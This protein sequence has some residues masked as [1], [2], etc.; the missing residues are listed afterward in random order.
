VAYSTNEPYI[1][2]KLSTPYVIFSPR[3]FGYDFYG[4]NLCTS[5]RQVAEHPEQVSAF[6]AAS[7]KGWQYALEHKEEI[8]DLILRRYPT[9]KTRDALLFEAR[10]TELLIQPHL[11]PIGDQT[12]ERWTTIA[13]TY[14]SLGMM[15]EPQVPAGMIY[16]AAHQNLLEWL[17]SWPLAWALL[18]GFIVCCVCGLGWVLYRRHG[19]QLG[20]LGLNTVMSGLFVLLSIPVFIF[21]L[22]YNYHQNSAAIRATLQDKVTKTKQFSLDEAENLINPVAA[23]LTLLAAIAADNPETFRNEESRELLYQVLTSARPGISRRASS[24]K[25]LGAI[26]TSCEHFQEIHWRARYFLCVPKKRPWKL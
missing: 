8:V 18:A 16:L 15:S 22:L 23:T 12:I 21:I 25:Q 13:N 19:R 1:F 20:A 9:Q 3:A 26:G 4:D 24:I 10:Q 2:E 11:V 6:R 5:K 17:E 14:V 7:L